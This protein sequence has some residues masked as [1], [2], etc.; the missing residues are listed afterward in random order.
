MRYIFIIKLTPSNIIVIRFILC[1][2]NIEESTLSDIQSTQNESNNNN[3]T[4]SQLNNKYIFDFDT[5]VINCR[6]ILHWIIQD[7]LELLSKFKSIL[8]KTN[9]ID[10]SHGEYIDKQLIEKRF[11]CIY[12]KSNEFDEFGPY[13]KNYYKVWSK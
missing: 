9:D 4:W 2:F 12:S 5:L 13:N 7:E 10:L 1:R 3:I 6:K 11:K 8:I